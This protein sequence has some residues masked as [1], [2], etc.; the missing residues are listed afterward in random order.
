MV[1]PHER[2]VAFDSLLKEGQCLTWLPGIGQKACVVLQRMG[3]TR[4]EGV[5]VH[6]RQPPGN[7]HRFAAH[8]EQ[9]RRGLQILPAGCRGC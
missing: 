7:R 9:A 2:A 8:G 1:N 6:R 4:P 5:G 3:K